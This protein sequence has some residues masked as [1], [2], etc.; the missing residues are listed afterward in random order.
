MTYDEN[1]FYGLL[2]QGRLTDAI[3]YLEPFSAQRALYERY[4]ALFAR[5]EYPHIAADDLTDELFLP[6]Q[7]YYREVF[8]LHEKAERAEKR[9]C[10]RLTAI[11][12]HSAQGM[13][14]EKLEQTRLPEAFLRSGLQF[15]GGRTGG[16]FGPYIYKDIEKTC[17]SVQLPDGAQE[18]TV[19]F[20]SGF[21][22]KS[23]LD[24]L[25][26]GTVSPGGWTNGD[27]VLCCIRDCYDLQSESFQVSLLKHEAQHAADLKREASM[28]P[29]RLEYRAKL[30]EL[31]YSKERNLL[32]HFLHEAGQEECSNGHSLAAA[33]IIRGYCHRLSV[34]PQQLTSLPI[35]EI[36][37][38][39]AELFDESDC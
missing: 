32:A 11:L 2:V 28:S 1:R 34:Q 26:F 8:Y 17:F 12:G 10:D 29:E 25:S 24:Y 22:S 36:Q 37:R 7:K 27:G 31:I 38:I 35:P 16:Y 3:G 20:L 15:W 33:K 5:E 39:A 4:Q 9:L 18:Y 6:Y 21:L 14:L 30:V 19:H 23:W 13:T